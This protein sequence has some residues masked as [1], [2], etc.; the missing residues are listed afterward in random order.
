MLGPGLSE[1]PSEE[2]LALL[3]DPVMG[4]LDDGARIAAPVRRKAL[5]LLSRVI[6]SVHDPPFSA[7]SGQVLL[8]A[9]TTQ[10]RPMLASSHVSDTGHRQKVK[11]PCFH[12]QVQQV[13][14]HHMPGSKRRQFVS[15][16]MAQN[17]NRDTHPLHSKT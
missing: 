12:N 3:G 1:Y 6:C 8:L 10:H 4:L 17:N 16:Y 15:G 14:C 5:D 9:H 2:H 7:S 11:L 13:A